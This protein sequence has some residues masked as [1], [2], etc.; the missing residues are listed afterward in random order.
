MMPAEFEPHR[1]T[2]M[3]W[4]ARPEIYRSRIAEAR[5]AHALLANTIARFE[6]V[7]MVADPR[8]VEDALGACE[9]NVT[10]VELV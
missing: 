9:G 6:P 4:P 2:V 5:E 10:V 7:V 1:C 8:H 3:C